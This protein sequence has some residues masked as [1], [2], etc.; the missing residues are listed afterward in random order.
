MTIY[1][2]SEYKL[3]ASHISLLLK[4][5]YVSHTNFDLV[6]RSSDSKDKV[7]KNVT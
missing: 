5:I 3:P 6:V 7:I 1:R 2:T 4:F